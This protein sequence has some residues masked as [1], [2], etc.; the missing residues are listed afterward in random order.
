MRQ[1]FPR[2]GVT[3]VELLIVL[4]VIGLTVGMSALAIGRIPRPVE[5][6]RVMTGR[7]ARTTALRSGQAVTVAD[8]S[9]ALVRFLPD[10]RVIGAGFDP[11]TGELLDAKR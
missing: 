11:L 6:Q 4:L 3:L 2:F 10:G 7:R 5:S 8:D 1:G 9:S